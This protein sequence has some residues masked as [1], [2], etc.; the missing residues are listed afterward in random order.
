MIVYDLV[1]GLDHTF[2]GWFPDARDYL[3]QRERGLLECPVCGDR[4]IER[5]PSAARINL[6]VA[7][8]SAA[9]P[10]TTR[11]PEP[12]VQFANWI[13]RNFEDVGARFP[14]EARRIHQG[15]APDR[16]IRGQASRQEV[17]SL[18]DE[19]VPILPLPLPTKPDL[20]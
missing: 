8:P 3:E 1:C 4:G 16:R 6:G 17:E 12:L 19:G 20:N 9:P 14:D 2:E 15:E 11:P 18:V 7:D 5:R 13:M 10:V